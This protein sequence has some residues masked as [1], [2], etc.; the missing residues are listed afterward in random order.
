MSVSSKKTTTAIAAL[1]AAIL[2]LTG[3]SGGAEPG[4]GAPAGAQAKDALFEFQTTSYGSALDG[5][6]TIRVPDALIDAAGSDA[7]GLLVTE[8]RT[9]PH[10]LSGAEY[11]AFDVEVTYAN[12]DAQKTAGEPTTDDATTQAKID[13]AEA[14]IYRI[15]K[16]DDQAGLTA[17][18][19]QKIAEHGV[20]DNWQEALSD[21]ELM[22]DTL[23]EI[24]VTVMDGVDQGK[25]VDAAVRAA[26]D[27][28]TEYLREGAD[29]QASLSTAALY[30]QTLASASS[31]MPMSDLN[32]SDPESGVY[33][34]DDGSKLT[35]V[36]SCAADTSGTDGTTHYLYFP[37]RADGETTNFASVELAS[38]RS[39]TVAVTD[40]EVKGY[41]TDS[42]G[43]WITD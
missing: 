39:G 26:I 7:D 15:F 42:Q 36:G 27:S 5:N 28:Q 12:A 23:I 3:C 37:V 6:L 30:G 14:K 41:T 35:L 31:A 1:G 21:Q 24:Y 40:S 38:M 19:Q 16:V 17:W 32:D 29:K 2:L 43:N 8:Y 22:N 34:S 11:C 25:T 18:F 20:N 33:V 10:E 9:S 13:E 4:N